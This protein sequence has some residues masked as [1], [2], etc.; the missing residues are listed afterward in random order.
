[1]AYNLNIINDYKSDINRP[2]NLTWILEDLNLD[3]NNYRYLNRDCTI[4]L[5]FLPCLFIPKIIN[6]LTL[7]REDLFKYLINHI[8]SKKHNLSQINFLLY[9]YIDMNKDSFYMIPEI[10]NDSNGNIIYKI[11][12]SKLNNELSVDKY[13]TKLP[14]FKINS[15]YK[16]NS[17]KENFIIINKVM[18]ELG[19]DYKI[20]YEPTPYLPEY[21]KDNKK[22]NSY[23]IKSPLVYGLDTTDFEI[24]YKHQFKLNSDISKE[25]DTISCKDE[26]QWLSSRYYESVYYIKNIISKINPLIQFGLGIDYYMTFGNYSS[27]TLLQL[28]KDKYSNF[29]EQIL[30]NKNFIYPFVDFLFIDNLNYDYRIIPNSNTTDIH[31][32]DIRNFNERIE[33][34]AKKFGYP[35]NKIHIRLSYFNETN[36]SSSFIRNLF[37]NYSKF[38]NTHSFN[39]NIFDEYLYRNEN[40]KN[41]SLNE[42]NIS[43]MTEYKSSVLEYIGRIHLDIKKCNRV[44]FN[45]NNY[46][47]NLLIPNLTLDI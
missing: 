45:E 21:I 25:I 14:F 15:E 26:I 22:Y 31:R 27:D 32:V 47:G 19:I 12:K 23:D 38:K 10:D 34:V 5:N 37:T 11:N 28:D 3:K 42:N 6:G 7:V 18:N 13:G 24:N 43:D 41:G 33:L 30:F 46:N 29:Q 35:L 4:I 17:I 44:S 39:Y 36:E 8:I 9:D 40:N 16:Y 1:M 2:N 20:I